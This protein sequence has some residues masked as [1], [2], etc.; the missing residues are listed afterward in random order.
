MTKTERPMLRKAALA[1]AL[2]LA[3]AGAAG[4]KTFRIADQPFADRE[5]HRVV[6]KV[7]GTREHHDVRHAVIH[8]RDRHFFGNEIRGVREL[9]ALPA[10][11]G[12]LSDR[13]ELFGEYQLLNM[14]GRGRQDDAL[15]R[16]DVETPGLRGGLSIRF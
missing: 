16:R 5:P 6:L 2:S 8:E 11:D 9:A 15:G 3:L 10:L 1:I 12:H 7:R 13:L 4:A 14:G